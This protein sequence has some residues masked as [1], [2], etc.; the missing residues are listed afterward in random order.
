LSRAEAVPVA[1]KQNRVS[2][3]LVV[4]RRLDVADV[5][6]AIAVKV[7]DYRLLSGISPRENCG[8]LML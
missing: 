4:G 8:E 1:R 7:S 3:A 2:G 6:F 5:R